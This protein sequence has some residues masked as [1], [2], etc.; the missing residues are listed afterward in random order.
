MIVITGP[1]RSGTSLIAQIYRELGFDPA[2]RWL[3]DRRAGL[4]RSDVVRLNQQIAESLR[5]ALPT[6]KPLSNHLPKPL[7]NHCPKPLSKHL[8]N[9]L[10]RTV[11][12]IQQRSSALELVDWA[13]FD[14]AVD[15]H[16]EQARQIASEV[17][18]AK[19]PR[20]A[21]TIGVWLAAGAPIEH[22]VVTV[23]SPPAAARSR[24]RAGLADGFGEAAMTNL[25]TYGTGLLVGW[26]T[27]YRTAWSMVSFPHFLETPGALYDAIKFPA[28]VSRETF[29]SAFQKLADRPE[30][31]HE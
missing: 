17:I 27:E 9:L 26:L 15:I 1:G 3:E 29:M 8:P 25:L 21:W 20:M 24:I 6:P 16:G 31:D 12:P 4:E 18:V 2:G 30:A 11:R 19:D 5:V 13:R 23:R 7:S 14:Q 28:P 22:V 10:A